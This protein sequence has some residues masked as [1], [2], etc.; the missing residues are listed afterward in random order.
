MQYVDVSAIRYYY[1][2]L[3]SSFCNHHCLCVRFSYE[4]RLKTMMVREEFFPFMEEV[5][6]SVSVMTKAAQG[7]I[8]WHV[9]FF[10]F[11][12]YIKIYF[13]LN[14]HCCPPTLE[15]LDCDDLHSVIRL[16]LK[17]GNYMNAVSIVLP[18]TFFS[19]LLSKKCLH[20]I[21]FVFFSG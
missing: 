9:V 21:Y 1:I 14:F 11:E 18:Q 6:D 7:N 10:T 2:T 15:L 4:Q 17:A 19:D 8:Y 16:V 20:A 12:P 3:S 5:K 13:P